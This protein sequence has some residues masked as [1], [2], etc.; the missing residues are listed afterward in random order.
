MR[1]RY[2][3]ALYFKQ[4][5]KKQKWSGV[6]VD[7]NSHLVTVALFREQLFLKAPRSIFGDK[8]RIG[9][10]FMVRIGKVDP[11]NNDIKIVEAW[12]E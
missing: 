7:A 11:L 4:N 3:K 6:I 12:E 9:Q 2:W 5:C 1:P 10:R 8:V